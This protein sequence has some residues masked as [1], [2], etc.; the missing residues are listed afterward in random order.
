[1]NKNLRE[2][3]LFIAGP[4]MIFM[5]KGDVDETFIRK[6]WIPA[7]FFRID[8]HWLYLLR[9]STHT[10]RSPKHV[11]IFNQEPVD[12]HVDKTKPVDLKKSWCPFSTSKSV[13]MYATHQADAI[14]MTALLIIALAHYAKLH[15]MQGGILINY[16]SVE[17]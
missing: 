9:V 6:K 15:S 2:K 3:T 14:K 1:M 7:T 10:D 17:K 8:V 5:S 4:S 12:S 16:S 11:R 13:K